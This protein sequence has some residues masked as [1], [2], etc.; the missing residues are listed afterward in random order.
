MGLDAPPIFADVQAIETLILPSHAVG[1]NVGI[2]TSV[3]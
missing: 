3:V 2:D 1:E